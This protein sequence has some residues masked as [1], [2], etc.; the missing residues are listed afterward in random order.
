MNL[1][2]L[3]DKYSKIIDN[4]YVGNHESPIDQTFLKEKNIKLIINC[5]KGYS[6]NVDKD[7]HMIRLCIT[8]F[9]SPENNIILANNIDKILDIMNI[10]LG[11][12]EGVL[13]HCHMG[14]QRSAMVVVCYL[15]KYYKM[16]LDNSINEVKNKR[17]YSFLPEI[18][19][20]DFLRYYEENI[21]NHN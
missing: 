6:Y 10:Y 1:K 16:N 14:Q 19:F 2:N 21:Y 3:I 5:T 4:L 7:V 11:S 17:K 20:E 15:M 18:T 13:V 12:N 9:N 8:D